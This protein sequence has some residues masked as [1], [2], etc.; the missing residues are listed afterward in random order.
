MPLQAYAN[1]AMGPPQVGFSFRIEPATVLYFYMFG[2]CSS[3]C[4]LLSGAILDGYIHPWGL[5]HWALPHCNPL[6]FTH[7]RHMCNLEMA[8]DPHQV[9]TEVAAPFTVLS[10]GEA[11]A[12]QSAV[13]PAIPNYM[14][15]H[16]S[17]ESWQRVTQSL[18]L[19]L[20]CIVQGGVFFSR[21]HSI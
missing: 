7:A 16:T 13:L 2:V 8:I 4:F 3:V 6:E 10:R 18:N 21:F 19:P 1:Y 11:Y 17:L 5:K 14:M 20:L 9:C 15:E 12:T